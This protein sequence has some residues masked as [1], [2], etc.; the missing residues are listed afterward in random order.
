ME[1]LVI[2]DKFPK[3]SVELS[4][5]LSIVTVKFDNQLKTKQK[6]TNETTELT[7]NEDFDQDFSE[8]TAAVSRR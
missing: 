1:A 4:P 7:F 3:G 6:K 2:S 8:C 5:V